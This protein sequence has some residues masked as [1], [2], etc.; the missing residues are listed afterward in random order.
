LT[1]N[2][3]I[4]A[5]A[6]TVVTDL[7]EHLCDEGPDEQEQRV[8]KALEKFN[9][10]T[11]I[12]PYVEP[13]NAFGFA[14]TLCVF[15]SDPSKPTGVYLRLLPLAEQLGITPGKAQSWAKDEYNQ[16]LQAQ[17]EN[18]EE[19]GDGRIGW[20]C[21]RSVVDLGLFLVMDDE[22]ANPDQ[23]GRRWSF[24]SEWLI[25]LDRLMS[26]ILISPWSKEFMANTRGLMSYAMQKSGLEE[27]MRDV[28]A[29]VRRTDVDGEE[30]WEQSDRTLADAFAEDRDGLSEAEA[31]RRAFSGPAGALGEVEQ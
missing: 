10:H 9:A 20:E 27:R 18:D 7:E 12:Q 3:S 24:A 28:K 30:T 25:S 26:L 8:I 22:E 23:S 17:R 21:L 2:L 29:I 19:R 1:V 6:R 11:P 16:S 4:R 31:T 14:H 13:I 5:F 15:A